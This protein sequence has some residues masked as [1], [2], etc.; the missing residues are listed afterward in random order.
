[1]D[2]KSYIAENFTSQQEFADWLGVTKQQVSKWLH[3][4]NVIVEDNK[5]KSKRTLRSLPDRSG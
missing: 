3:T 5:L 2:L 4:M 1:M